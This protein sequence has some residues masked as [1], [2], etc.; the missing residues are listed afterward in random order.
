M[1]GSNIVVEDREEIVG[2]YQR[3]MT[4]IEETKRR[5]IKIS[6]EN[7]QGQIQEREEDDEYDIYI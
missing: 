7:D 3:A 6:I 1:I 4:H 5:A 2:Q